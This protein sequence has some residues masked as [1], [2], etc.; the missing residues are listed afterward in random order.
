MNINRKEKKQL[1]ALLSVKDVYGDELINGIISFLIKKDELPGGDDIEL[2]EEM[3]RR[4][5]STLQALAGLVKRKV[6]IKKRKPRIEKI[7]KNIIFV[8]KI[9]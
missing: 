6:F 3:Q 7:E 9:F 2:T 4:I 5:I 8:E 1:I